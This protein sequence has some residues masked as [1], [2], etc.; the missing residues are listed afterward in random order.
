MISTALVT[1]MQRFV[2]DVRKDSYLVLDFIAVDGLPA[3]E[4]PWKMRAIG[5]RILNELRQSK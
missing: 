2:P 4:T 3:S 5:L 1:S